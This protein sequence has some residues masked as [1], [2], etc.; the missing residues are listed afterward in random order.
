VTVDYTGGGDPDRTL[1]LLWRSQLEAGPRRGPRPS[2]TVDDVVA[3]AVALAD[4]DGLAAVSMRAVA[5]RLGIAPMS[6]YTHVPGKAELLDLMLDALY[7]A[8]PRPRWRTPSW[9]RRVARV[10]EVNRDLLRQH[11]WVTELAALSR[12][13]LGPGQTAKYEHELAAFDGTGLA[14]VDVDAA[15]TLVLGFAHQ[16]A[17]AEHDARRAS[18]VSGTT[19]LQWWEA[20]APLLERVLDPAEYPRAARIGEAAGAAQGAAYDPGRSWTFGLERILAG[21]EVL[22]SG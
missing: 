21:L 10:A 2:H 3:V 12:P 13:P 11:P 1:E 19:D 20:N 9:R 14:D 16:Q 5:A 17:R 8:M 22:V 15:L 7:A 18:A 6:V 4:A